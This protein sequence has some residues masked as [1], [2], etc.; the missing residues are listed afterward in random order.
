MTQFNPFP[1]NAPP[2]QT[3]QSI[4]A[5]IVSQANATW[6]ATLE[7]YNKLSSLLGSPPSGVTQQDILN[8]IDVANPGASPL[9]SQVII[10][11]RSVAKA[12]INLTVPGTIN[13]AT[14]AATITLPSQQKEAKK[15]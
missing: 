3:A 6:R 12:A 4:A 8:A 13:D 9:I 10:A 14:V 7:G 2:T 11:S 1:S 5:T 15:N